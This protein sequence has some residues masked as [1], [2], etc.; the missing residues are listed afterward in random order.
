MKTLK[1]IGK[2]FLVLIILS[3]IMNSIGKRGSIKLFDYTD[4]IP[5]ALIIGGVY[6]YKTRKKRLANNEKKEDIISETE[7]SIFFKL[8]GRKLVLNNPFRGIFVIGSAGSGKTESIAIPL[9][10]Q[11]I[12]KN[13]TGIVYD[14][15]YPTLANEIE[16]LIHS[17]KS[18]VNHYFVTFDV[19]YKSHKINPISPNY[20]P[21]TSYAGEYAQTI[22]YN[23]MKETIKK[24]DYWSRSAAD[25]LTASIWFLRQEHPEYCDIPHL[26]ALITSN[27]ES[28]IQL[29][30]TNVETAPMVTSLASAMEKGAGNQVAGVVGTL[31]GSIARINTP[32]LMYVFSADEVPLQVNDPNNPIILTIGNNPTLTNALSP[33]C[34][35]IITVVT[36]LMNQPNKANSFVLLDEAP[37]VYIPNLDVIPNTGRSNKI[38][39]V[40]MCQDL[41]QLGDSY[42]KEKGDVLFAS[43]NNHFYGR[44]STSHSSE[45]L[46]KQFGK[47]N[48]TFNTSSENTKPGF[49]GDTV[50]SKGKSQSI[51]E[52]DIIKPAEF[53]DFPVGYFV[54]KTVDSNESTFRG[55][56]D[57]I[58]R[59]EIKTV[60]TNNDKINYLD[61]YKKVREDVNR[62]L[63]GEIHVQKTIKEE[64]KENDFVSFEDFEDFK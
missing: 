6:W 33:L 41:A 2:V 31:Q 19:N 53:L 38:S 28:L 16:T 22:M 3:I 7:Y 25:I 64:S 18:P 62:I 21:S 5:I 36:K 60:P 20:I 57:T 12:E 10:E 52:R 1:T 58:V 46:S 37:T 48:V 42:G 30:M 47:E 59:G 55:K 23:L 50:N 24:P 15:K 29:L 35:L 13:Y 45:I 17:K 26:F 61:Y 49:L 39:T 43:C 8:G 40:L 44:V 4:I 32:E 11:F 14:F 34:S 56:F 27:P 9:L 54:G 63:S 51:Q